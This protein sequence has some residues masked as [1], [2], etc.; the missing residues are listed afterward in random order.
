VQPLDGEAVPRAARDDG[1]LRL[2]HAGAPLPEAR[3]DG[4]LQVVDGQVD[5]RAA[6]DHCPRAAPAPDHDDGALKDADFEELMKRPAAAVENWKPVVP[7]SW[8]TLNSS[9][10]QKEVEQAKATAENKMGEGGTS[11]CAMGSGERV[12]RRA[13]RKAGKLRVAPKPRK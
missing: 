9:Q 13:Q 10:K 3:D 12:P 7:S 8:K 2:A 11:K 4:P 1:L 6:R 5:P